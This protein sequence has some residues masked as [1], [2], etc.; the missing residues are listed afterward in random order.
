MK[1]TDKIKFLEYF[2][3]LDDE[4]INKFSFYH[5]W[6]LKQKVKKCLPVCT[7]NGEKFNWQVRY[8][9]YK[10]YDPLK[11]KITK[12]KYTLLGTALS[13]KSNGA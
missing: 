1:S 8:A 12:I 11:G 6:R 13:H 7:C 5:R 3:R 10:Q 2:A 9:K 4:E